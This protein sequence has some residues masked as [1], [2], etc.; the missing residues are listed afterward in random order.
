MKRMKLL[1]CSAV[2]VLCGCQSESTSTLNNQVSLGQMNSSED[3]NYYSG[4]GVFYLGA[5][6]ALGQEIFVNYLAQLNLESDEYYATVE[7][8]SEHIE[9]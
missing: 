1:A 4:S 3:A 6:D 2:L 5:G 9:D 8:D 7:S